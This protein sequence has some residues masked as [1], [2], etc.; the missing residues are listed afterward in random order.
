MSAAGDDTGVLALARRFSG[1]R[2]RRLADAEIAAV[3]PDCDNDEVLLLLLLLLVAD[4]A[5]NEPLSDGQADDLLRRSLLATV[6]SAGRLEDCGGCDG[7]VVSL[8]SVLDSRFTRTNFASLSGTDW[9]LRTDD[10]LVSSS[11]SAP[12]G[13]RS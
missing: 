11:P 3:P 10:T 4:V 5:D 13:V 12:L 2:M 1:F 6:G 9:C 8:A 7:E